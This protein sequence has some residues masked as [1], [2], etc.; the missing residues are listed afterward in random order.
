MQYY[1]YNASVACTAFCQSENM[2]D[3][4]PTGEVAPNIPITCCYRFWTLASSVQWHNWFSSLPEILLVNWCDSISLGHLYFLSVDGCSLVKSFELGSQL[5][6]S[7]VSAIFL[8]I[9]KIYL[10]NVHE[11]LL[12]WM[13]VHHVHTLFWWKSEKSVGFLELDLQWSRLTFHVGSENCTQ[14]LHAK[15][16]LFIRESAL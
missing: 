16:V 8:F 3:D 15:L 12:A 14:F 11:Y 1:A 7:Q 2:R 6:S 9:L 10:F 4:H 13:S 5:I